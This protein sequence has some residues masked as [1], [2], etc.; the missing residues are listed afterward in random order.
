MNRKEKI[1]THRNRQASQLGI[2]WDYANK[3][4]EKNNFANTAAIFHVS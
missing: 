1:N 3:I 4:K 2:V